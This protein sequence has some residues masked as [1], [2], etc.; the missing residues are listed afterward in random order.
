MLEH[1]AAVAGAQGTGSQDV[2]LTLEAVELH[3]HA[4]CHADPAC[5]DECKQQCHDRADLIRQVQLE[6]GRH[7]HEGDAAQNI[8]HAFHHQVD[9]AAVV[10]LNGAVDRADGQVDGRHADGQ[11]EG[12]TGAGSQTGEDVLA[13]VV[14]AEDELGFKAVAVLEVGVLRHAH[15]VALGGGGTGHAGICQGI[16][17]IVVR[18]DTQRMVAGIGGLGGLV[19]VG[20]L[21]QAVAVLVHLGHGGNA[22]LVGLVPDVGVGLLRIGDGGEDDL[23]LVGVLPGLEVLILLGRQGEVHHAHAVVAVHDDIVV[24]RLG[25]AGS[26]ILVGAGQHFLNGVHAGL[27]ADGLELIEG[28]LVDGDLAG[29]VH[30]QPLQGRGLGRQLAVVQ[31]HGVGQRAGVVVLAQPRHDNGVQQQEEDDHRSD[32][33]GLIAAET[34]ES[35]TEIANRLALQLLVVFAALHGDKLE[36]RSRDMLNLLLVHYFLLPIRIRGSMKP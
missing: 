28:G 1:Q 31:V 21:Q 13:A 36:F 32:H 24:Q 14:G 23:D 11:D 35:V 20:V 7:D 17:R 4:G 33:A 3:T 26:G 12:E 6:Q 5:Q 2:L 27:L 22:L 10:T 25:T 29:T 18:R 9:H 15:H 34:V 30:A 16:F 19:D 8:G